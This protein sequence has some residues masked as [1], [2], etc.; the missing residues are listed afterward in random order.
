[1][2]AVT[3]HTGLNLLWLALSVC[4][5]AWFW[6]VESRRRNPGKWRRLLAVC[7]L[8]IAVFPTVSDTDDL[9]TFS[10]IRVPGN[11]HGGVGSAPPP[12]EDPHQ[13]STVQLARMLESLDH[14]QITAVYAV[15]L[16]LLFVA[17]FV[18]PRLAWETRKLLCNAG[19]APPA[20]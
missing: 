8:C 14:Y 17:L 7:A 2:F 19:R 3:L 20:A 15:T 5:L 16:T 11:P 18:M 10:L 13:K 12:P 1:V 6:R 9:F 4:A